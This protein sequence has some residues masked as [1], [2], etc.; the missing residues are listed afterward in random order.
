MTKFMILY[1]SSMSA[2]ELMANAT[3]EQMKASMEDWLKWRDTAS[4]TFKVDF[5]LPLQ[6]VGKMTQSGAAESDNK[7]SGYSIVDGESKE[8]LMEILKTHPPF[9]A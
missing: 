1:G 5:G 9:P 6:A 7:T 8:A 2:S 4:K 3:P